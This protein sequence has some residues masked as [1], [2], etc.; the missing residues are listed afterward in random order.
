MPL[1]LRYFHPSGFF[2]GIGVSYVDQKVDRS[3]A[4]ALADGSSDFFVVDALAGFRLP[5]RLRRRVMVL[6]RILSTKG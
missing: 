4:S 2:A 6:E 5:K 3:P 1:A